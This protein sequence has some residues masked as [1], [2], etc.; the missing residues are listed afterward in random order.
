VKLPK[1]L[2]QHEATIAAYEGDTAVGQSYATAVTVQCLAEDKRRLVKGAAGV[3]VVST[4]TIYCPPDTVA[5]VESKVT[6]N[7][8]D[9]KVVARSVHDGGGLPVPSHVELALE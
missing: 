4:T 7:G 6:V 9:T 1:F 5:P 2:L 3:E 8:R